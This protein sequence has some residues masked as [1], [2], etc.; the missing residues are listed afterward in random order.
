M[1]SDIIVCTTPSN[2]TTKTNFD[3]KVKIQFASQ[4]IRILPATNGVYNEN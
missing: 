2:T 4:I 3:T 1:L